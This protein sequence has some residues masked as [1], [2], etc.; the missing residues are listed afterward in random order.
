MSVV[1]FHSSKIESEMSLVS[2]FR[3]REERER[4]HR[5]NGMGKEPSQWIEGAERGRE[6]ERDI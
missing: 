6:R 1:L 4:V 5:I 2:S 3:L